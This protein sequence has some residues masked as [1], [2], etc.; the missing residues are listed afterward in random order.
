MN[1][2]IR[3]LLERRSVR[4]FDTAKKAEERVLTEIVK[5]GAYAPSAMN[6]QAWH[7]TVIE[8]SRILL[9]LNAA[10]KSIASQS[11]EERIR[12]RSTDDTYNFYYNAPA[13]IV[14]SM[15]DNALYPREDTGCCMQNMM[16][17]ATSL[18][19]GTCWIN[20]LG[21]GASEQ[22]CV[23]EVLD[24][25]GV[26]AGNKVYAALAVGYALKSPPLKDRVHGVVNFVK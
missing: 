2:T 24:R 16:I 17:A 7:F 9:D 20:Q 21:N 13:L 4:S 6:R 14:V 26:P 1:A 19:V 22:P 5:A 23:R 11:E 8:N 3:T 10:V 12:S 15:S 18:G 25:A